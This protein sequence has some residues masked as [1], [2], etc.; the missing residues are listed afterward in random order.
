MFSFLTT[1]Q[2]PLV[3]SP[4]FAFVLAR[5]LIGSVIVSHVPI[6]KKRGHLLRKG[7]FAAKGPLLVIYRE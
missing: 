1:R 2:L 7:R 3:P 6:S 5:R 4:P